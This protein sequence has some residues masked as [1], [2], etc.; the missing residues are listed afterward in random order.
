MSS[1]Q[2]ASIGQYQIVEQIGM[3]GMATVYKAYQP[4]LDRFVAVK[5]L[6]KM[7]LE[8]NNFLARFEREGRIVAGLD[9]PNIVPVYDFDTFQG[10]PYLVMKYVEGRTLKD[11]MQE[12]PL[13]LDEV[14]YVMR[15]VCDALT[16]AHGR[17]VL[18]RDI[19]P[20]NILIDQQGAPYITDFGLARIAQQG[21]STLSVDTMLGTPHYISPEQAQGAAEIDGRTDIYSAGIVLYELVIGRLPFTGDSAY[22]VIHK[23][24]NA[25][26]PSP[27]RLNPDL[28]PEVGE[29]LLK[30][31]E[32]D[33]GRRYRTANEMMAAFDEALQS[34]GLRELDSSRVQRAVQLGDLI[35]QHTPGGSA[36]DTVT[37]SE[38][39]RK[40][41]VVPVVYDPHP[42][43]R[44]LT[45]WFELLVQRVRA[46]IEDIR[47]QLTEGNIKGRMDEAVH[48]LQ[49]SVQSA[50][51]QSGRRQAAEPRKRGAG[52]PAP[53]VPREA[54]Q[55]AAAA[56]ARQ[57]DV[58]AAA[59]PARIRE[60]PVDR[61]VVDDTVLRERARRRIW[62]RRGFM[63]HLAAYLIV[64][65]FLFSVV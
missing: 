57:P 17:G 29:V 42:Q 55:A 63:A 28:P 31:L 65:A 27:T 53:H 47:R 56:Q 32:K 43:K 61:V 60:R 24:I 33:P 22:A 12:T 26:P 44:S 10:Q 21:E 51:S 49:G 16:Y 50:I 5:V 39:G 41:V 6:H 52:T 1:D 45:Q 35:S 19:K 8:E 34:A 11:H 9:H 36:Y 62:V 40:A 18:H 54:P 4:K 14:L 48:E 30:A 20:S 46:L 64:M 37:R 23:Q 15:A 2:Q 38:R 58:V 25:A 3:G 59:R 7:F 13:S